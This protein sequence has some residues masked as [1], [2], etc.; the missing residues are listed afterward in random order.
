MKLLPMFVYLSRLGHL[1]NGL[2][3]ATAPTFFQF[4][5]K[6]IL[7]MWCFQLSHLNNKDENKF[8]LSAVVTQ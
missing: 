8:N 2:A 3:N 7:P 4:I 6:N 5:Y 1:A